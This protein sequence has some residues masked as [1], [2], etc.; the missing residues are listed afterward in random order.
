MTDPNNPP[1]AIPGRAWDAAS[2]ASH[3]FG[4]PR[5]VAPIVNAA[6]PLI[7]AAE[8][9]RLADE[10]ASAAEESYGGAYDAYTEVVDRL[11]KRALQ[12]DGG[13]ES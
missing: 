10:F 8:L 1:L 2:H 11:H 7:V 5:A 13:V 4:G 6:A 3:G 9:R 12:L